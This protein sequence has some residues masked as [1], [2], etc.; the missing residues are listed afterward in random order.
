M[1]KSLS[2]KILNVGCG[3]DTCGT[4]FIDLYPTRKEVIKCDVDKERIP[5]SK[6]YFDEVYC[7]NIFEHLRKPGYLIEESYRVLKKGGKL[8][9]ITDNALYW[10]WSVGK[11]HHGG[12]RW[13]EKTKDRHYSLFTIEH[14]VNHLSAVGFHIDNIKFIEDEND[15]ILIKLINNLIRLTPF[16][17]SSYKRILIEGT[18]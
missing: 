13:G 17:R 18:K 3:N 4:H 9:I 16:W 15:N 8:I 5:F 1:K 10:V 14:L 11:T 2:K 7:K 6:S 12:Y